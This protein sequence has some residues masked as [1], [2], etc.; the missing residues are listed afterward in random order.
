MPPDEEG[1][2][3]LRHWRIESE[4]K[5]TLKLACLSPVIT[6]AA[7]AYQTAS[8]IIISTHVYRFKYDIYKPVAEIIVHRMCKSH[9]ID[10][11]EGCASVEGKGV[12][13]ENKRIVANYAQEE[14]KRID[15]LMLSTSADRMR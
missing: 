4:K 5:P 6:Y 15:I 9:G 13:Q 3:K 12:P 10:V 8:I 11:V 2:C 1:D 14:N 7:K